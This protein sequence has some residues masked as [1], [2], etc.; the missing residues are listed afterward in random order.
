MIHF[1]SNETFH[2]K[3]Q[4]YIKLAGYYSALSA[5]LFLSPYGPVRGSL[6]FY[7]SYLFILFGW[8]DLVVGGKARPP[9]AKEVKHLLVV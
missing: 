2:R 3:S 7:A 9:H 1:I 4:N 8:R 5:L 6:V